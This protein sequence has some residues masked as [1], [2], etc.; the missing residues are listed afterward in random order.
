[1]EAGSFLERIVRAAA[2]RPA[3]ILSAVIV[4]GLGGA[5]LASGL[6][7]ATD[8]DTVADTGSDAFEAT[9]RQREAFGGDAVV[10]L[11]RENLGN[12]LL[13]TPE[14]GEET[15]DL[16]RLFGLEGCL[17]GNVP[18]GVTPPG[19]ADGPCGQI[20]DAGL[21]KVVYGPAT[22]INASVEQ[23]GKEFL[24]KQTEAVAKSKR[25]G[26][27]AREIARQR[28]L[29]PAE[30]RKAA[31][32]AEEIAAL[33]LVRET[34]QIALTYGLR[35]VPK[36]GDPRFTSTLVFD[37][38][39]GANTPKA[40]FASL[41]PNPEAALVG[42]RL[43]PNLSAADRERA[44]DLVRAAVAMPEWKLRDGSYTVTGLPAVAKDVGR[45]ITDATIQL[46][47]AALVAM[48]I[49]LLL[50]FRGR[51]RLLPLATAL[52]AAA[53]TFGGMALVGASLTLASVA[54]VPV[55]IGLAV[56]YAIQFQSRIEEV[57]REGTLSPG[58]AAARAARV[59]GPTIATATLA[60]AVGFLALLLSPVPMVRGFGLA[61]VIGIW[62]ALACTLT[63]G[64]ALYV[65][66]NRAPAPAPQRRRP[67]AALVAAWNGAV[68]LVLAAWDRVV[69][70]LAPVGRALRSVL[71]PIGRGARRAG[72]G[73][74]EL[75]TSRPLQL[76]LVA[77]AFAI[78]GWVAST[79]T[80]VDSDIQELLPADLPALQD[81]AALQS[82]TGVA[83]EVGVLVEG[84]DLATPATIAWMRDLRARAL[85]RYG[86]SA[87]TGCGEAAICPATSLPDL[88]RTS[89]SMR[90][91]KSVR[92]VVD[93]V[94]PYFR[95]AVVRLPQWDRASL[96]FGIRLMPL[97]KQHEVIEWIRSQLDDAPP[98]VRAE[99]TGLPA[100]TADAN[101]AL[102]SPL[103]RTLMMLAALVAV[104]LALLLVLRSPRRALV[105]LVPIVLATGWSALMVWITNIPLNPMSAALGALVIAVATEFSVLLSGRYRQ[106]REA[107][108]DPHAALRRTY[109][110]TG[111]A[112]LASGITA[113]V[114]F[115]VL[116]LS[117]IRML[118][119][120]GFVT[121]VD[122]GVSLV[123]VLVVLPAVLLLAEGGRR[124]SA[125]PGGLWG[126]ARR[127][128]RPRPA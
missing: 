46:L 29:P 86:Y 38:Q 27:A 75:A 62:V 127:R 121:V 50:V 128:L 99:V 57:R 19:G 80:S 91:R 17:S 9:E 23:I 45:E 2:R 16:A 72:R 98:G 90:D 102:G 112:V 59:G 118:S 68:D 88:Y 33:T 61:L 93:A 5:L 108:L 126:R 109:S 26:A 31:K 96:A 3:L 18:E 10:V 116:V 83:G 120:F 54:V 95:S 66:A 21:V 71:T 58:E 113:I 52:L 100:L 25:A 94:P 32:D 115:G 56:D 67:V 114:G 14:E 70:L 119:E 37:D 65:L 36:F 39:R 1:M 122:L 64:T 40:R 123:G 8:T 7:P 104:A 81:L 43:K 24:R 53:I 84:D 47:L 82:E 13:A 34:Y 106:E 35:D 22:F 60:T 89:A 97:D 79:Q 101:D 44:I 74:L 28:G 6:D 55:L 12:L 4:L 11:V 73:T 117:D 87:D 124:T 103:R 92:A 42:V 48:A 49:V 125:A 41:F 15:P 105:P 20:A 69:L 107:G 78:V 63:A 51:P 77:G 76:L 85:R 110:S 111:V 30:Q